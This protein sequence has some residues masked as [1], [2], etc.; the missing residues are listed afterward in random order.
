MNMMIIGQNQNSKISDRNHLFVQKG[1]LYVCKD[2]DNLRPKMPPQ[3]LSSHLTG[4][5]AVTLKTLEI[6]GDNL[7]T[8]F[9][10]VISTTAQALLANIEVSP[11]K[12][13]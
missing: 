10:P 2:Y 7:D 6:I 5:F 8:P 13:T 3:L 12:R 11:P 9:L 1:H 4:C